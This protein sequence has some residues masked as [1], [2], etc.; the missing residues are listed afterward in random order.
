MKSLLM[1]AIFLAFS[2]GAAIGHEV[3]VGNLVFYHPWARASIGNGGN[4]AVYVTISTSASEPD[5]LLA[6]DTPIAERALI[7]IPLVHDDVVRMQPV[8][9]VEIAP[10][11]PTVLRPGGAHIMLLGLLEPLREYDTFPLTLVFEKAGRVEVEV[12]VEEAGTMEPEH[13]EP[14]Q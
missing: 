6:A 2:F 13:E 7:H 1:A 12:M 9:A 11:E 5:R 8:G 3:R 4:S 10:G 14:S